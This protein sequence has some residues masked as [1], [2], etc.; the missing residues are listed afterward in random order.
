MYTIRIYPIDP[1]PEEPEIVF[2]CDT[3]EE[4][5]FRARLWAYNRYVASVTVIDP[6]GRLLHHYTQSLTDLVDIAPGS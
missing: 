3:R 5:V 4:A 1:N 2:S 6:S